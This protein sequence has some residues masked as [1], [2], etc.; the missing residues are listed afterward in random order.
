MDEMFSKPMYDHKQWPSSLRY[1]HQNVAPGGA[2][3]E[4]E[5]ETRA[6]WGYP[7]PFHSGA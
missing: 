6:R 7:P 4:T 2:A 5:A 1:M 3:A